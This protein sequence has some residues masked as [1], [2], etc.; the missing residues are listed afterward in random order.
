M[1]DV[2]DHIARVQAQIDM[3]RVTAKLMQSA[4]DGKM[5]EL[6][7]HGAVLITTFAGMVDSMA[8]S[9][10]EDLKDL[11]LAISIKGHQKT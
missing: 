6:G 1:A 7:S 10:Q 9:I 5:F 2:K 8:T 4:D 11:D 3:M